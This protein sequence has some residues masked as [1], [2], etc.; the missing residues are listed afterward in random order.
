M[1]TAGV[2]HF[3]G[4][5][6]NADPVGLV[7]AALGTAVATGG[8]LA[9]NQYAERELDAVMERTRHR[10]LPAGRLRPRQ[11]LVFGAVLVL[12]GTAYLALAA[13]WLPA[14]LTVFS[15]VAYLGAYTPLKTR[16]PVAT[17]VGAVPGAMPTLIGWTAATGSLSVE[18]GVFFA[19]LFLWQL[20]HVL[21]LGWILKDDY[22]RAGIRLL[23]RSDPFGR[24][25]G[26]GMV[27]S[28]VLLLVTSMLL[29]A[30]GV[31]GSLYLGGVLL[32]GLGL[33][34]A[35]AAGVRAMSRAIARRVFFGTLI[36][37]PVLLV[38]IVLDAVP[39]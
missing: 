30:L 37:H 28:S 13:G 27:A 29:A 7:H 15:A 11:A 22:A 6:G 3:L 24:K 20:P 25:I 21:A 26:A 16:T 8:A 39:R 34:S 5:G 2:G 10:P 32:A 1:L 9:L 18:G 12:A 36:Y 38:L 31:T 4:S 14:A 23:P 33:L 17:L 19:T 35:S